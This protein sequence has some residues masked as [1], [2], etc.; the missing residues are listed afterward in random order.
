MGK[1]LAVFKRKVTNKHYRR[2]AKHFRNKRVLLGMTQNELG[3]K[4]GLSGCLISQFEKNKKKPSY[5]NL[6]KLADGLGVDRHAV[7]LT[8]DKIHQDIWNAYKTGEI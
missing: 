8:F 7:D 3:N 6:L 4:V 5:L 2:L 1:D